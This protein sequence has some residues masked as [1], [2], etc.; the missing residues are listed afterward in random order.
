MNFFVTV[1][2]D[3][4]NNC[5]H[6]SLA[7]MAAESTETAETV[8]S[9]GPNAVD[10]SPDQDGGILKE[11]IKEGT[12]TDTPAQGNRV[13][14]HYVGT[15]TDGTKFDSSRDRGEPFEFN[16]G[17]GK[18]NFKF[19]SVNSCI[20]RVKFDL[21]MCTVHCHV[22]EDWNQHCFENF[23]PCLLLFPTVPMNMRTGETLVPHT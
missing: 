5:L 15:L 8:L 1:K 23:R 6:T 14:V 13:F 19:K 12:G 22:P 10:V 7:G 9:P 16:L 3:L 20:F 18:C 11:V 17:K 4:C 2:T 21:V